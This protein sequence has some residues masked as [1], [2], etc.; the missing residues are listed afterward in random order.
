MKKM[1]LMTPYCG[2][3]ATL[4]FLDNSSYES[5]TDCL[6]FLINWSDFRLLSW[7]WHQSFLAL[8]CVFLMFWMH[9]VCGQIY[10]FSRAC[11]PGL[12][13]SRVKSVLFENG[14]ILQTTG[15]QWVNLPL[16][17]VLILKHSQC[18]SDS[19][20]PVPG[21]MQGVPSS[22]NYSGGFAS[23]LMV[24]SFLCQYSYVS[25]KAHCFSVMLH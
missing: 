14:I 7:K 18:G 15:L 20:N 8:L 24:S 11:K 25:T 19:Y 4:S 3:F 10:V 6:T 12:V 16:I 13:F 5:C 9:E 17:C 22:R 23:K 21:V 2:A 1:K